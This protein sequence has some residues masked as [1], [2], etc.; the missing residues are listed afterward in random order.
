M[1]S[2]WTPNPTTEVIKSILLCHSILQ[3]VT[4]GRYACVSAHLDAQPT[5]QDTRWM[6][7]MT[8]YSSETTERMRATGVARK[9][10][11]DVLKRSGLSG[12]IV[13]LTL[14]AA[15]SRHV[16]PQEL[17]AETVAAIRSAAEVRDASV[18]Q[19]HPLPLAASWSSGTQGNGFEPDFQITSILGGKYLLPWFP[20]PRPD[21]IYVNFR[22][23]AAFRSAAELGLP[24][25]FISTQWDV[26]VAEQLSDAAS[27]GTGQG[28]IGHFDT[29]T[30]LQALSPF[31]PLEA[32]YE[33]GRRWGSHPALQHLEAIYPNPPLVLF[34]SNNEQLKLRWQQVRAAPELLA[35]LGPAPTDS[36]VRQAVG[37]GWIARYKELQRG[38]RDALIAPGWK[39]A[40]IFVGYDA[41][42]TSALGRWSGWMEYSLMA[43]GRLEHWSRALDGASA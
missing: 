4:L 3:K 17:A 41:F 16:C 1:K 9:R 10:T 5:I 24:V 35:L 38:F 29:R 11:R 18:K 34:L 28:R 31:G 12:L 36:A 26:L 14:G 21:Q 42:G 8:T 6:I 43:P 23:D 7:S 2:W 27:V 25:S 40:A 30:P 33:A 20:L 19:Q 32:W 13:T 39:R 37:D 22:D 15:L